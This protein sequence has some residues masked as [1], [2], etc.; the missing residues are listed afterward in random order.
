MRVLLLLLAWMLLASGCELTMELTVDAPDGSFGSFPDLSS[1]LDDGD[2]ESVCEDA[3]P[4]TCPDAGAELDAGGDSGLNPQ[5]LCSDAC[6]LYDELDCYFSIPGQD[7]YPVDMCI[8]ICLYGIASNP[9]Y[10]NCF[11]EL[12]VDS[13][14]DFERAGEECY[15]G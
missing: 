10:A 8:T 14:E 13:C 6:N 12:D 5:Q 7:E 4:C 15:D 9:D 2:D 1:F 3:G 11:I